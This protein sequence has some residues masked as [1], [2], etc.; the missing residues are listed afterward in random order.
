MLIDLIKVLCFCIYV[1]NI[2]KFTLKYHVIDKD[3]RKEDLHGN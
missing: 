2:E 1:K 3:D